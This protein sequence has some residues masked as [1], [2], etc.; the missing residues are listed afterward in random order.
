MLMESSMAREDSV[1]RAVVNRRYWSCDTDMPTETLVT[2]NSVIGA[3][4][5]HSSRSIIMNTDP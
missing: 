4:G 2:G 5:D 1:I 3:A